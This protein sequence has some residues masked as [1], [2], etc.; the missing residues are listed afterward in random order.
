M[1]KLVKK[2]FKLLTLAI[3]GVFGLILFC[4]FW[5]KLSTKDQITTDIDTLP[6]KKVC[7]VLG[8]SHKLVN[9]D[10][11]LFFKYRIRAA[12]K[13]YKEKK[14]DY[15][16]VSGDNQFKTYNEPK[17][18]R[19]ALVNLGIPYGDIYLDY[20]GFRTFDSV[21]RCIEVFGQKDFVIISQPFHVDRAVYIANDKGVNAMGYAANDIPFSLSYNTKVRELLAKVKV[22]IDLYI[23]HTKPRYLG[24]KVQIGNA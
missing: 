11:N 7:L 5:I 20:A 3:F 2:I 4:N 1:R 15:I 22:F 23:L 13:L 16:L 19:D 24:D 12:E 21:V 18:M 6:K 14:V 10:E 17:V 8:T 9:G